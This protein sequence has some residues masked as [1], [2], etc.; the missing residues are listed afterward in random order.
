MMMFR[1][2]SQSPAAA[3]DFF[4][5]TS[6][7][8]SSPIEATHFFAKS[9]FC[10]GTSESSIAGLNA[11]NAS[12][13]LSGLFI[14][15]C[16]PFQLPSLILPFLS[17][18]MSGLMPACRC[19]AHSQTTSTPAGGLPS[20]FS[21]WKSFLFNTSRAASAWATSGPAA[22]RSRSQLAAWIETSFAIL[23]HFA[24]SRFAFSVSS[25]TF[26][27]SIPT[28]VANLSAE[29]AFSFTKTAF[30]F[31][32]SSNAATLICVSCSFVI[33]FESRSF[34]SNSSLT[35]PPTFSEYSLMN[36]KKDFGVE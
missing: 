26:A 33:P 4:R 10:C 1:I 21:S 32:S 17:T 23:S 34:L 11:F 2:H 36:S 6:V 28:S 7:V 35:A 24:A 22:A 27:F 20:A 15:F 14:I 9:M 12:R 18:S 5:I 19:M 16:A 13:N 31:K 30:T 25:F 29:S 3:S 8:K